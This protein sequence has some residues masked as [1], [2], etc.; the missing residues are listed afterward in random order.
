MYF[1]H[2]FGMHVTASFLCVSSTDPR[3]Q[4]LEPAQLI[5]AKHPKR[6]LTPTAA[7]VRQEKGVGDR[8]G[9]LGEESRPEV[10]CQGASAKAENCMQ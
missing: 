6:C 7:G 4:P 9:I 10:P 2:L 5:A 8:L 3:G 1:M